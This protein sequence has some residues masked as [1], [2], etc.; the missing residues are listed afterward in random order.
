MA[1]ADGKIRRVRRPFG[2]LY[3]FAAFCARVW[4]TAGYGLRLDRG[5]I[6]DVKGPVLLLC[7]HESNYDFLLCAMGFRQ[8]FNFMV[9]TFFFHSA[10]LSRVLRLMGCIPKK[11]FV[12]DAGAIKGVLEV[13]KR[14][15]SVCIF[16]EG[17]VCY[18]GAANDIDMSVAKL[19]KKLGMTTAVAAVRGNYLSFPKWACGAKF[20]SR[21]EWSARVLFTPEQLAGASVDEIGAAVQRALDYDDFDWQRAHMCKSRRPRTTAGLETVLYRCPACERDGVM[22]ADGRRLY[23]EKC[24]YEVI[25]SDACFFERPSGEPPVYDSVSGWFRYERQCLERELDGGALPLVSACTLHKTVDG[26]QGY[27]RC[28]E[29]KMTLGERGLRFEGIKDGAPFTVAALY[30]HQTALTHNAKLCAVDV[31][32]E[33]ENFALAPADSRDLFRFVE[34]YLYLRKRRDG[35]TKRA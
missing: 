15:G 11:Q 12:P 1:S 19:V 33:H 28:G 25:L 17:Q 3:R 29:G 2:P 7:N 31:A 27:T 34:G 24:G 21:I 26:K 16:P 23:C 6:K 8:K 35:E 22:R 32:G 20:P 10:L 4:L 14:G 13:A 30:E 9:S 18:S 5:G